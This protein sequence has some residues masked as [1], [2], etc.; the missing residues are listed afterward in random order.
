MLESK[1]PVLLMILVCSSTSA[2]ADGTRRGDDRTIAPREPAVIAASDPATFHGRAIVRSFGEHRIAVAV[3]VSGDP[4]SHVFRFWSEET[5]PGIDVAY[6]AAEVKFYGDELVVVAAEARSIVRFT[7]GHARPHQTNVPEGF[8]STSLAGYGLNHEMRPTVLRAGRAISA[9]QDCEPDC[10][11]PIF[12]WP[13]D[14]AMDCTSGG[15]GSTSCS[16][17]SSGLSCSTSCEL[18]YYA[19][20]KVG[21]GGVS[22]TCVRK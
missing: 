21:W 8:N 3:D 9:Q 22:C 16:V 19:C 7:V 18:G 5:L 6:G 13:G 2:V 4:N 20:C 17:S 15:T 10:G 11:E 1:L 14:G 12:E